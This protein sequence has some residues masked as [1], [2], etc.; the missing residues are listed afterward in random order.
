MVSRSR[1]FQTQHDSSGRKP[2]LPGRMIDSRGQHKEIEWFLTLKL[3]CDCSDRQHRKI[4]YSHRLAASPL[5]Q[6]THCRATLWLHIRGSGSNPAKTCFYRSLYRNSRI[7]PSRPVTFTRP[8]AKQVPAG[9]LHQHAAWQS[10]RVRQAN[11]EQNR[12]NR[13]IQSVLPVYYVLLSTNIPTKFQ[14]NMTARCRHGVWHFFLLQHC[15]TLRP[16]STTFLLAYSVFIK[17]YVVSSYT[18]LRIAW[19]SDSCYNGLNLALV[20]CTVPQHKENQI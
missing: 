11:G 10:G 17:C 1:A 7:S 2:R 15:V 19:R 20:T 3:L 6:C 9:R 18:V 5:Q 13:V 4:H 16:G 12:T 8:P 14:V